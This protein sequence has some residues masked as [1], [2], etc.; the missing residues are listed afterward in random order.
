M[1]ARSWIRNSTD[2]IR[3]SK[4]TSGYRAALATSTLAIRD[5]THW[6]TAA[7]ELS[8]A[9]IRTAFRARQLC[10]ATSSQLDLVATDLAQTIFATPGL[11]SGLTTVNICSATPHASAG[12]CRRASELMTRCGASRSLR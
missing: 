7:F 12:S 4:L 6:F 2:A 3:V 8:S 9:L 11:G 10:A 5:D 1:W